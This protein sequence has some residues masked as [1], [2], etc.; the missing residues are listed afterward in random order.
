MHHSYEYPYIDLSI[1]VGKY[2]EN[3]H[4]YI[5]T[6]FE[7]YIVLPE[8]YVEKIGSPAF[9]SNWEVADGALVAAAEYI[10]TIVIPDIGFTLMAR[11]TCLGNEILI[12]RAVIDHLRL[13]FDQGRQVIIY[14]D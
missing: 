13:I 12:G 5:D 2:K 9:I 6:G 11:I 14:N 4:A 8:N 7:G 1:S 10:G 3:V